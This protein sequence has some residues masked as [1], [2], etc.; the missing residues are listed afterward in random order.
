MAPR[1]VR[2]AFAALLLSA[3]A[4]IASGARAL[5]AGDLV[6]IG[7]DAGTT[8]VYR[9]DLDAASIDLLS[10]LPA[11][12]VKILA[13]E[14]SGNLLL[15]GGSGVQRL[16]PTTG[17]I[18]QLSAESTSWMDVAA[19]GSIF[20][21]EGSNLYALDAT[22]GVRTPLHADAVELRGVSA[23]LPGAILTA[24]H[25]PVSDPLN[26]ELIERRELISVD[27]ATSAVT[28]L[29]SA[30]SWTEDPVDGSYYFAVSREI[31]ADLHGSIFSFVSYSSSSGNGGSIA[32]ASSGTPSYSW[33]ELGVPEGFAID[34]EGR[35]VTASYDAAPDETYRVTRVGSTNVVERFDL[36]FESFIDFDFVP[37]PSQPPIPEPGTALLMGLGL[38][39]LGRRASATKRSAAS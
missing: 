21:A 34:A 29:S 2:S 16:D 19:D 10:P 17:A 35:L 24:R 3:S 36:V 1:A 14:P 15:A 18:T 4:T 11:G 22:T 7:V 6:A 38:A 26:P 20:V 13:A 30:A 32:S 39:A 9:I 25:V 12:V 8:G 23:S 28:V 37:G 27:V 5:V 33:G 31:D